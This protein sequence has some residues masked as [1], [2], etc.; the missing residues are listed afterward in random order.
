MSKIAFGTVDLEAAHA[1]V[2]GVEMAG[3]PTSVSPIATQ[4]WAAQA[5]DHLSHEQKRRLRAVSKYQG[6]PAWPRIDTG[7]IELGLLRLIPERQEPAAPV[8][9]RRRRQQAVEVEPEQVVLTAAGAEVV[10]H[11]RRRHAQA[12]KPHG[13]LAG[14]LAAWLE[15][16][17]RLTAL[18]R[19]FSVKT[20]LLERA[21]ARMGCESVGGPGTAS[22]LT[23]RP[24]VLSVVLGAARA[25]CRP[26]IHEVKVS[27]GDFLKDA[28][29]LTKRASY[30]LL[31]QRVYY[32]CPAGLVMPS[33]VPPGCGLVVEEAPGEFRELVE[34]PERKL[35]LQAHLTRLVSGKLRPTIGQRLE[36]EAARKP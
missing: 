35:L 17:G 31:A 8:R 24:D 18:N 28:S 22:V 4:P 34:A 23:V 3:E 27:R 13:A 15:A 29:L 32:A 7:L 11:L 5:V 19:H 20:K 33:E 12:L 25:Q 21:Y 26:W 14:R 16:Q 2:P 6:Y 36:V 1:E 10:L 9:D 30:A